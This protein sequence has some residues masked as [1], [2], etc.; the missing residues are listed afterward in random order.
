M[1]KTSNKIVFNYSIMTYILPPKEVI[2]IK[3]VIYADIKIGTILVLS[4]Y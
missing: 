2:S 3:G 4:A 1:A